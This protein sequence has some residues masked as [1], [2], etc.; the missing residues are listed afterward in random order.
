MID[1]RSMLHA[2]AMSTVA[3]PGLRFPAQAESRR[4]NILFVMVDDLNCC[5][6]PYDSKYGV[7]SPNVERL[8]SWGAMFEH[9]YA[10]APACSPSRTA[11]MLGMEPTSTGV[12]TN[13]QHWQD[14]KVPE[15]SRSLYGYFREN[16]W[17]TFGT[18]KL[19]HLSEQDIRPSDW[20]EYWVPEQY[21]ESLHDVATDIAASADGAFD[22]GPNDFAELADSG[23]TDWAVNKIR[24]GALDGGGAFLG[25]GI[26]RPHLPQSV[27]QKWFD[28][29]PDPV[30]LPP[31]YWPG[32]NTLDD[33][34]SDQ[35]DLGMWAKRQVQKQIAD[36]LT[37][38]HELDAFLR[39]YYA[40]TTYADALLG[41][42]LDAIEERG[43]RN[44]TYIVVA[45]DHGFM[46]GEKRDF[47]KFKLREAAL[48]V[49]FFI[50]GPDIAPQTVA[51]PVSLIDIFPTLCGLAGIQVPS[52]CVGQDLSPLL[53]SGTPPARDYA[54]SYWGSLD[55]ENG[56]FHL[57]TSIRT[58]DWR[59]ISY[60]PSGNKLLRMVG[61]GPEELE[62]YDQD[63]SSPTYDRYEW[64][65]LADRRSEVIDALRPMLPP[66]A[67]YEVTQIRR[68]TGSGEAAQD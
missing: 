22:F 68:G 23:C 54:V 2:L 4:A 41:R 1:R 61:L 31:G 64:Y 34:L 15:G 55:Q 65:N 32:A 47:L 38:N 3:G 45:S 46:L 14:A 27:S 8:K 12:F 28:L 17:T 36:T 33:N 5:I 25:L 51:P 21:R 7:I 37:K 50:V 42:V 19:S 24:S 11:I 30:T 18:G 67:D 35:E 66:P 44:N 62:L 59:L 58:P 26:F 10:V 60:G 57:R 39:S 16:G 43:L 56:I 13:F 20:N 6:S 63:P 29:Y 9:A 53:R 48:Q 49:P 40:S 52:Y